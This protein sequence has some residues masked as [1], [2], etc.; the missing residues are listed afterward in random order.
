MLFILD[1]KRKI[2]A[3]AISSERYIVITEGTTVNSF[4]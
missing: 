2:D 4:Y 1:N 3:L